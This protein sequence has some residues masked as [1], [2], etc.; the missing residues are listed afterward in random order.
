MSNDEDLQIFERLQE[1]LGEKYEPLI[2]KARNAIALQKLVDNQYKNTFK[3]NVVV[4][5][6]REQFVY[7]VKHADDAWEALA[8]YTTGKKDDP[9]AGLLDALKEAVT[10]KDGKK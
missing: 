8:K 9:V 2:C 10:G 7:L 1:L 3:G 6:Q 4:R 5:R